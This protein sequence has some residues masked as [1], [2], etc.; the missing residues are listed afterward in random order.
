[1][2][3]L[4]VAAAVFGPPRLGERAPAQPERF[5]PGE[6]LAAVKWEERTLLVDRAGVLRR[7]VM[8]AR[9]A[10]AE[11]ER[12]KLGRKLYVNYCARCHGEDGRSET[13]PNTRSMAGI[14]NRYSEKQILEKTNSTASVDL[15]QFSR[16]ELDAI[17]AFVAGL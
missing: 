8:D 7:V 3:G 16:A 9:Q 1:M 6:P 15:S 2:G 12:W 14:G 13:Y 10:A 5:A 17:A 11:M 4:L